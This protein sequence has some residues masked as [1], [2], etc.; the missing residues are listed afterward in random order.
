MTAG[1]CVTAAVTMLECVNCHQTKT[2]TGAKDMTKHVGETE[3]RGAVEADCNHAGYTGDTYC[4]AC[5]TLVSSGETIEKTVHQWELTSSSS[6][7]PCVRAGTNTYTCAH[8]HETQTMYESAKGHTFTPWET[9]AESTCAEKG[10]ETRT[11]TQCGTVETR[12][13]PVLGHYDN[14]GDGV[15]DRCNEE[16]EDP[17][18]N[19]YVFRCTHCDN[20]EAHRDIPVIGIFYS[21]VHFFIHYGQFIGFLARI[22]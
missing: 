20:Y 10:S 17:N 21:I 16:F 1:D 7:N 15:C 5:G 12:A 22:Y 19:V 18:A 9:V 3:L 11:C 4:L 8:C 14:D 13:L 6:E 2:E